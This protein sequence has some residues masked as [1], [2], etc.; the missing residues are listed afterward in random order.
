MPLC[1]AEEDEVV[2]EDEDDDEDVDRALLLVRRV[3]SEERP[4]EGKQVTVTIS[5][6]NAGNTAATG[7]Q[8]EDRPWPASFDVEGELSAKFDRIPDGSSVQHSYKVASKESGFYEH[9]PVFVTYTPGEDEPSQSVSSPILAF[10]TFTIF[11]SLGAK[12][13][14]LGSTMTGGNLNTA[15]DWRKV[16]YVA[17]ALGLAFFAF[18][19]HGSVSEGQRNRKRAKALA[20]LGALEKDK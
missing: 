19:T 1:R 14:E 20:E 9:P 12:A 8:V 4:L 6:Y 15:A 13:L 17:G 18:R 3:V 5:I 16:A 7:V 11:E 10:R 2:D